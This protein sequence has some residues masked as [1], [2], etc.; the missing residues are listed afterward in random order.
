MALLYDPDEAITYLSGNDRVLGALIEAAGPF[1]LEIRSNRS[2]FEVLLRSIVYQQLSDRAAGTIYR[3]LMDA[4]A[5][6][7]SPSPERLLQTPA[8]SLRAAGL[9]QA[10][11]RASQDLA[12]KTLAGDLPSLSALKK[13]TDEEIVDRLTIVRG[14]G[15]WTVHMLLIF[16]LG[17]P[18]VLPTTDLGVKK[19]FMLTYG[20][21][22]LPS[23]DTL[24]DHGEL[25][26][27]FRSVASWYLWRAVDL[28]TG[29]PPPAI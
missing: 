25:W 16:H 27:P 21:P 18:D 6:G 24:L 8:D 5:D 19:G 1:R 4:I 23:P 11:I 13:M 7:S 14:I 20:I 15:P 12:S 2:V 3:R 28:Q 17:R 26:R 9:S 22:E 10:K 29:T